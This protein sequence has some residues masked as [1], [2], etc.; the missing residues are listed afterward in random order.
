MHD[1]MATDPWEQG[2]EDYVLKAVWLG[3]KLT[4]GGAVL[5]YVINLTGSRLTEVASVRAHL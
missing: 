3:F 5:I 2:K 4:E 1:E